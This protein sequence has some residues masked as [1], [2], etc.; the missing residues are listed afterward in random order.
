LCDGVSCLVQT[1]ALDVHLAALRTPLRLAWVLR[2]ALAVF[3]QRL[4]PGSVHRWAAAAAEMDARRSG[5]GDADSGGTPVPTLARTRRF[6]ETLHW[7]ATALPQ[8]EEEASGGRTVEAAVLH[9]HREALVVSTT[10]VLW[11]LQL[12]Q[13]LGEPVVSGGCEAGG[14]SG[15]DDMRWATIGT[16]VCATPSR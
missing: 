13:R 15:A 10:Q 5:S 1:E 8:A 11:H 3:R 2:A 12:L 6:V 14:G 16:H 7:A 4:A 9:A